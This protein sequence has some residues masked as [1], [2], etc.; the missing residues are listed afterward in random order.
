MFKINMETQ[1][2]VDRMENNSSSKQHTPNFMLQFYRYNLPN[3]FYGFL[4]IKPSLQQA[5][6][7]RLF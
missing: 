6:T 1:I 2:K 3:S 5:I 7:S 4:L